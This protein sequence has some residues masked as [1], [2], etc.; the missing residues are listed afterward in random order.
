[1]R[2]YYL[3]C[4]YY[5]VLNSNISFIFNRNPLFLFN[6][7]LIFFI[8]SYVLPFY[9]IIN[10]DFINYYLS[11]TP[12]GCIVMTVFNNIST[13]VDRCIVDGWLPEKRI[14]KCQNECIF[15]QILRRP[16]NSGCRRSCRFIS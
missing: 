13:Y 4:T 3:I 11:L 6:S 2:L 15:I 8:L 14:Q 7:I 1:M 10:I 16:A 5:S 12:V 9:S